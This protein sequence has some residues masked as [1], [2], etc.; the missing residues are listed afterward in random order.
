MPTFLPFETFE[1]SELEETEWPEGEGQTVYTVT[2]SNTNDQKEEIEYI[3]AGFNRFFNKIEEDPSY[4]K[5]ELADGSNALYKMTD[6]PSAELHWFK[7]GTEYNLH[8]TFFTKDEET[9]KTEL[10]KVANSIQ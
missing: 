10:I 9:I 4:E 8:Y 3:V 5:V 2:Y 1:E 6:F 7:D